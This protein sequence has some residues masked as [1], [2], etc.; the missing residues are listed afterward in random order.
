MELSVDTVTALQGKTDNGVDIIRDIMRGYAM[1]L[2][3]REAEAQ[4]LA[5]AI[6]SGPDRPG[7]E[8]D[9][10]ARVERAVLDPADADGSDKMLLATWLAA[11]DADRDPSRLPKGCPVATGLTM[12]PQKLEILSL[13]DVAQAFGVAARPRLE[14]RGGSIGGDA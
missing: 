6:A 4:G 12:P 8:R 5:L 1:L 9:A 3:L 2:G 14:A 7:S 10:L 11:Q 13:Q